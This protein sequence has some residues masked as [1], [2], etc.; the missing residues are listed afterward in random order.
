MMEEKS[1]ANGKVNKMEL[2][3]VLISLADPMEDFREK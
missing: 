3:L 2:E 1:K